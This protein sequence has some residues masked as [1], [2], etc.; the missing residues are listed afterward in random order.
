MIIGI[1]CADPEGG[2]GG[3]YTP[4]K[5]KQN[6]GFHCNTGSDPLKITRL[7]SQNSMLGHH[8]HASETPLK[9]R[10]AGGLMMVRF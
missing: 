3:P 4:L 1:T 5:K 9:W 6:I 7:P 10:F 8:R 2:T